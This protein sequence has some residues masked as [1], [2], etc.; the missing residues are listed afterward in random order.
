MGVEGA[1][2]EFVKV[3]T[4]GEVGEATYEIS[5]A[6]SV[7]S[8]GKGGCSSE[9][10]LLSMSGT[11]GVVQG[12]PS[13]WDDDKEPLG[14]SACI[15]EGDGKLCCDARNDPVSNLISLEDPVG[16]SARKTLARASRDSWSSGSKDSSFLPHS[17]SSS[18]VTAR[19]KSIRS[20]NSISSR[21]SS[22]TGTPPTRDM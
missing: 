21:F 20:R 11:A 5:L 7:A 13:C 16:K 4:D 2:G 17:A 12:N 18:R 19:S 3:V 22:F 8:L 15:G 6:V 10:F 1:M 9:M 14:G